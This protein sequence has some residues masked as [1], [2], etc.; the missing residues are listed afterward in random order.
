MD[1]SGERLERTVLS[2][3]LSQD[4]WHDSCTKDRG[5]HFSHAVATHCSHGIA[6]LAGT[7][8]GGRSNSE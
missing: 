3:T 7:D 6:V 2:S 1:R 8:V 4:G 5:E